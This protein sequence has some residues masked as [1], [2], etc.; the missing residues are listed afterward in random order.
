MHGRM[1]QK[2][3]RKV[4]RR[5]PRKAKAVPKVTAQEVVAQPRVAAKKIAA[6]IDPTAKK[7]G[8]ARKPAVEDFVRR[9]KGSFAMALLHRFVD[10]EVMAQAAALAFY[11]LLSLAPLLLILL[12][13]TSNS[14]QVTES[15]LRQIADFVGAES[16]Q[17]ART[18]VENAARRPDVSSIAGWWSLFWLFV[19]ATAVF[20]QLQ[21]ALNKIFRTD[22][23]RLLDLGTW[24]RKRVF[25]F[26]LVFALAFLLLVSMTINTVMQM[27][28]AALPWMLPVLAQLVSWVVYATAFALM[29]HYL[30]DRRV[31]WRRAFAGGALTAAMF[32]LGRLAIA[33]YLE[34][35]D[36]ARAYG[37]TSTL[38]ISLLWIYYAAL[39]VFLGAMVT[40]VREERAKAKAKAAG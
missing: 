15:L 27:A 10:A 2:E 13:L 7:T 32:V 8:L 21:D 31:E 29:Y 14:P 24:L 6:K 39:V 35:A 18:I 1:A 4:F 25:S 5:A 30:P 36:P 23:T 28:F 16:G 11:A 40:A 17:V 26:G 20:A 9:A 38:V 12:W 3:T 33:W 37:S 19:G 22:A 34:R